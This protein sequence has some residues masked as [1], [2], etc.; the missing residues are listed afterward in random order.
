MYDHSKSFFRNLS[1]MLKF[2]KQK[3]HMDKL[4]EEY[5]KSKK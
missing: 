1:I 2:L 3:E 4:K 5:Q